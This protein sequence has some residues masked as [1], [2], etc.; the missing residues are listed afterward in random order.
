MGHHPDQDAATRS[1]AALNRITVDFRFVLK[2]MMEEHPLRVLLVITSSYWVASAWTLSLCE[3][4][5]GPPGAEVQLNYANSLWLILARSQRT[6]FH[7][8]RR[9]LDNM[10]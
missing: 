1:I 2:T 9:T 4:F 8:G 3:R 6:K 7:N 10:K 5:S